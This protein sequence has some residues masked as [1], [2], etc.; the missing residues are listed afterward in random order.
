MRVLLI[1]RKP[2]TPF[3]IMHAF[4]TTSKQNG[5]KGV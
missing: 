4:Q 3:G 2:L 5:R 1:S